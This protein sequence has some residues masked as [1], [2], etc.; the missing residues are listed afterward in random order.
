M[1]TRAGIKDAASGRATCSRSWPTCWSRDRSSPHRGAPPPGAACPRAK[2]RGCRECQAFSGAATEGSEAHS[3]GTRR[4]PCLHRPFVSRRPS[5]TARAGRD[6]FGPT[7]PAGSTASGPPAGA[8][9]PPVK[10]RWALVVAHV[11]W[12]A[13]ATRGQR[14]AW[15]PSRRAAGRTGP[16]PG[17]GPA[18]QAPGTPWGAA[19]SMDDGRAARALLWSGQPARRVIAR[20]SFSQERQ[21]PRTHHARSKSVR[22]CRRGAGIQP[23]RHPR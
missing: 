13:R 19:H 14:T 12:P 10:D 3:R 18:L 22:C 6:A 11:S 23:S 20:P 4:A 17:S 5:S 8:A 1:K 2:A 15:S 21:V 9:P 7:W 16:C